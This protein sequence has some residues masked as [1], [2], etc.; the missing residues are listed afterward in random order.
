MYGSVLTT[1]SVA[2]N[3]RSTVCV[4][5]VLVVVED[6][7]ADA[8]AADALDADA[9]AAILDAIAAASIDPVLV[10]DEVD[11]EFG[12]IAVVPVALEDGI[13]APTS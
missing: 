10:L 1:V 12:P 5:E 6:P 3:L 8:A 2:T 4:E 13:G 9:D 7:V 11:T